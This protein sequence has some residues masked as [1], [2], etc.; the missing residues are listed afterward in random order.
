MKIS[1]RAIW[2]VVVL[3]VS[4]CG[5]VSA[6]V[7]AG[8]D[9]AVG[10]DAGRDAGVVLADAG[11]DAGLF[12]AG[13]FDGGQSDAGSVD[14]GPVTVFRVHYPAGT[15]TVALRGSAGTLTWASGLAM[16]KLDTSTWELRVPLSVSVEWKPLL[17]DSDWSEGPNYRA[18][19]GATVE[20]EPRFTQLS[21]QWSRMWVSFHSTVLNNTRGVYVYLPPTYLENTVAHFPVVYMHDGQNLFDPSAAFGG[22]TWGVADTMNAGAANG[23]IAEA[24]VIGV[25]NTAARIDEYTP[26]HTSQYGGGQADAYLQMLVTELK[27]QVDAQLRTLTDRSHT[28]IIGSSLG[29]LVSAY[30]GTTQASTFGLVGAMSPSTWWDNTAILTLVGQ[31]TQRPLRVYVDSGNAG[32]SNDDVTNTAQLAQTY[33]TLGYTDGST[34]RYVMQDGATHT[35]SAWASRLPGALQFLLGP[36]R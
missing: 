5:P 1:V 23:S 2:W 17:D 35:E 13:L 7:D 18:S 27:P 29:G 15:H 14:A 9:A 3:A 16:Q 25:E 20:V 30:A 21:G 24:I 4:A 6:A 31:S 11:A 32:Q 8:G 26:T 22:V 33:R 10:F 12:D 36:G 28:A 34:L 19:P